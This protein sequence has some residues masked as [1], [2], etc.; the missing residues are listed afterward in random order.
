MC[1]YRETLLLKDSF[2]L[3][4]KYKKHFFLDRSYTIKVFKVLKQFQVTKYNYCY[5]KKY[6]RQR[7]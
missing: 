5:M 7:T 2:Y 1:T 3:I 6:T 4:K